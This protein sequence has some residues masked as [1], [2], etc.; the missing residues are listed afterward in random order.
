MLRER[1]FLDAIV[2]APEDN[3]QR[4]I[5]A[6]WLEENG[7]SERAEF[8]RAQVHRSVL[9]PEDPKFQEF[10]RQENALLREYGQQWLPDSP[11]RK[12]LRFRR[13]LPEELRVPTTAEPDQIREFLRTARHDPDIRD[14]N[15]SDCW[16]LSDKDLRPLRRWPHLYK[17][18]LPGCRRIGDAAMEFV[19]PLTRL[20]GINLKGCRQLTDDGLIVFQELRKL[21]A[22]RLDDCPGVSASGLGYLA[23]LEKLEQLSLRNCP[24]LDDMT[25]RPL[26]LLPQL[27]RLRLSG[28][29]DLSSAGFEAL[30]GLRHLQE[31]EIQG[32][33][34]L[35]GP[36][37]TKL[38]ARL[39]RL[40]VLE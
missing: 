2:E 10:K 29:Q 30:S 20:H 35:F 37:L 40:K 7:Q 27:K 36:A 17:L 12:Y 23:G 4:L 31:L 25:F 15:L 24:R 13:G 28:C 26:S 16:L 5:Y 18:R 19:E 8:I 14:L 33:Y 6:D 11:L 32:C 38:Q 22:V 9:S 3:Y 39:P 21:R 34:R 1:D